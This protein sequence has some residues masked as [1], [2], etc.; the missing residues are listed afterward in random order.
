M[1]KK[2]GIVMKFYRIE[3]W[4]FL[5]NLIILAKI[6]NRFIYLQFNCSIP[7]TTDIG[8]N[9]EIAHGIG[10]VLHQYSTIG[11]GTIIYQNV[12]LGNGMG[13]KVGKNCVIGSGACLLGNIVIG[14]NVKIGANAV[15]LE[16][17]PDNCTAVGVPARI[18]CNKKN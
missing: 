14:D 7:Y 17:I 16:D 11:E 18:I 13:P 8:E 5:H 12:T 15:V 4:C 3:R 2:H 10:I 1:K 9:V 6:I